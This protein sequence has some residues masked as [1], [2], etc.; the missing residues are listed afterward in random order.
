MYH[1]CFHTSWPL[2]RHTRPNRIPLVC[3]V[4]FGSFFSLT[5]QS[6]LNNISKQ[7]GLRSDP[8]F[9]KERYCYKS[10]HDEKKGREKITQHAE[11][12][13]LCMHADINT[14]F[15]RVNQASSATEYM[16]LYNVEFCLPRWFAV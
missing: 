16:Y 14:N 15:V 2:T 13:H 3:F 12:I 9:Y 4:I 10:Y 6:P 7:F 5:V 1:V 8:K 11:L